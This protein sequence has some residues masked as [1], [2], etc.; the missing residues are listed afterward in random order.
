MKK[1]TTISVMSEIVRSCLAY[2]HVPENDTLEEVQQRSRLRKIFLTLFER[3]K[4]VVWYLLYAARNQL[5]SLNHFIQ[6][7][8]QGNAQA[9]RG[10]WSIP[11]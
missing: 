5:A 6:Q 2:P 8:E 7:H 10:A 3:G 9:A 1:P 4:V 11:I